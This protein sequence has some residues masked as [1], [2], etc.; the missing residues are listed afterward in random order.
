MEFF[1]AHATI[2]SKK[3]GA[4]AFRHPSPM[5]AYTRSS[6]DYYLELDNDNVSRRGFGP[7]NGQVR[8][9]MYVSAQEFPD[10]IGITYSFLYTFQGSQVLKIKTPLKS[11]EFIL[12]NFGE[13]QGDIEHVTVH[14]TKDLQ[15]IVKVWF[16]HHGDDSMYDVKDVMLE[17]GTHTMVKVGMNDHAS[18]NPKAYG[19]SDVTTYDYGVKWLGTYL[20][21]LDIVINFNDKNQ[22]GAVWR[23]Q[24]DHLVF[25]GVD[26][27][28]LVMGDKPWVAFKGD[29]GPSYETKA[30]SVT[31]ID[32]SH[33]DKAKEWVIQ[34]ATKI[35]DSQIPSQFKH[36][37]GPSGFADREFVKGIKRAK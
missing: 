17:Q 33:V 11:T 5:D 2:K 15:R 37:S 19:G 14:V 24:P 13:H 20:Y 29:L 30:N 21:A 12:N 6:G 16:S 4:F 22:H 1:L 35:F 10:T 18:W 36:T 26:D 28:G 8:A 27:K 7:Q 31:N 3:D 25:I 23:A 9:P 32:G 34:L